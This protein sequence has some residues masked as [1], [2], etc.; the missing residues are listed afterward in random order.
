MVE[1]NEEEGEEEERCTPA[2]EY[3]SMHILPSA[4]GKDSRRSANRARA[5]IPQTGLANAG[6]SRRMVD[7]HDYITIL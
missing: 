3:V 7:Y 4:I 5:E 1:E 2:L 6:G